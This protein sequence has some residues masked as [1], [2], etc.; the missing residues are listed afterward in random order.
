[1]VELDS[2]QKN[3]AL[4]QESIDAIMV[5]CEQYRK[6]LIEYCLQ[7]F[8]C[9]YEHAEDCVQNAYVALYESLKKGIKI[10]NCK[11]WLYSVTLNYKNKVIKDKIT[12][13][14]YEFTD[15]EEKDNTIN[16]AISYNPDYID[17][18]V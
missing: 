12:R 11:S 18:M 4:T 3:N 6:Q 2:E 17:S 16:N 9:E 5:D 7:Y 1:M 13:N 14:E 15:N 10:H 8:E